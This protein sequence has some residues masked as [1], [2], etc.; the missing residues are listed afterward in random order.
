MLRAL[1]TLLLLWVLLPL[2]SSQLPREMAY[3]ALYIP[4]L[5]ASQLYAN[6]D[7]AALPPSCSW[8]SGGDYLWPQRTPNW[9][10]KSYCWLT[11]TQL[12]QEDGTRQD[13][14]NVNITAPCFGGDDTCF[15]YI[16]VEFWSVPDTLQE[17][18]GVSH[19][20]IGAL[21]PFPLMNQAGWATSRALLKK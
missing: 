2:A 17:W 19:I 13:A 12:V 20:T 3:P 7:G 18:I 5:G 15:A 6:V 8:P 10:I 14:P 16:C 4:G 21:D 9:D 1:L 11:I